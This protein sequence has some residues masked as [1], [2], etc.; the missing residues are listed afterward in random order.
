A[1]AALQYLPVPLIVL[2]SQ[3]TVILA[4]EAMGRLLNIKLLQFP[5]EMERGGEGVMSVTDILHGYSIGQLGIDLLQRGSPILISWEDFLDGVV[6]NSSK[7]P[8]EAEGADTSDHGDSTSRS[9]TPKPGQFKESPTPQNLSRS[10]LNSTTI[11][12]TTIDVLISCDRCPASK[13][14]SSKP[15]KSSLGAPLQATMIISVWTLEEQQYITLTFTSAAPQPTTR[16][17]ERSSTRTVARTN[18]MLRQSPG[19]LSSS[20][21][22]GKGGRRS[23]LS[24]NPSSHGSSPSVRPPVFP[25]S[26][27]PTRSSQSTAHSMFAKASQM[28]DAIL[29][30]TNMPA[31]AMWKDES[32]GIPNRGLLKLHP[33]PEATYEM[34]DLDQSE[35]LSQ[36]KMYTEDFTRRLSVDEFPVV[37]L[38]RNQKPFVSRRIGMRHPETGAKIIFTVHGEM[39]TDDS[40]QFLGGLCTFRDDTDLSNQLAEQVLENAHQLGN[41]ANMIPPIVWTSTSAGLPDWFSQRWYDYTGLT[42]EESLGERWTTSFHPDDMP[43]T[44]KRWAHS[45]ATGD[46]YIVEYRCRRFD[47]MWRWMLGRALPLRDNQGRILKWFGTCTD[48]HELVETRQAAKSLREQ[49]LKVIEHAHVTLWAVD[50]NRNLTL[51]EGNLMWKNT[52]EEGGSADIGPSSIGRNIYEVFGQRQG[53]DDID[54]LKKPIEDILQDRATEEIVE[55][56]IDGSGKW[57]RSRILPLYHQGRN[58]GIDSK[59][60]IDGVIGLSMDVTELRDRE[61]ELRKQERENARLLANAVAAK[62]ASR[63]KSQFLA[64][65]SHEIRTPIAG[66]IGM[67]EILMDTKLDQEQRDCADNIQR[68]ANGLLTVINDILDFSKVESGRLDIEEV[69]FSLSVA[70]RDVNKMLSFAAWKKGLDYECSIASEIERD[71]TVMGDPGRVRQVLTNLLTNSIKFTTS[72]YVHLTVSVIGETDNAVSVQFV[73]EDTGIGIEE[74][75]RKRLFKPFSQADSSTARRFGGTGLGLTIS[76]NLVELMHGKIQLESRLGSG[77]KATFWIP[78]SKVSYSNDGS[79]LVDVTQIPDRLQSDASLSFGSDEMNRNP[80]TPKLSSQQELGHKR[81]HSGSLSRISSIVQGADD[82]VDIPEEERSKIHVLIVEDNQIN[83]QIA[84]K[85]IKKLGFSVNAVWNG[86]EALDYLLRAPTPENPR[87]DIILMDVQMPILDGYRATHTIRTQEPFK[88]SSSIRKIPIVA[89]TASAIQGD[90]EKCKRAGMDDYLAKPVKPKLLEKML[91]K[92]A[93]E[94][95]RKQAADAAKD[96]TDVSSQ[97]FRQLQT[98]TDSSETPLDEPEVPRKGQNMDRLTRHL[99]D[100]LSHIDWANRTAL[101]RSEGSEHDRETRRAAAEEKALS[102]RD[103]KLL[104][105]TENPRQQQHL[106]SEEEKGEA[107]GLGVRQA[108]TKENM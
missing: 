29:N 69:Q 34:A 99:S 80:H 37:D 6:K 86:R 3:K 42:P 26:G 38:V 50:R 95:K 79:P 89:M 68:S 40:G 73:V 13:S 76:K 65:M 81:D 100:K 24:S 9:S 21:S 63:M 94:A 67:S 11:H 58:D 52:P 35:F 8:S 92:W 61:D 64:N 30:S 55:I 102:L 27:P 47:G 14:S 5:N 10:N 51:L 20:S 62:E 84:L 15:A 31:Y 101:N 106:L 97:D 75:V 43:E 28:K 44:S 22:Q 90:R 46:E 93:L 2:S 96:K 71:L 25:P 98:L 56:H 103:D 108:L 18:T 60:F 54:F 87:P 53:G 72:G 23:A 4:N 59:K 85:T 66:V 16:P 41:I 32:F 91:V 7:T 77:T 48:I 12:E 19:S 36:F 33:N 49:L 82:I 105:M 17:I 104:S 88:N 107:R 57:F 83:Q 1:F 45:L 39:I 70:I 78:F 74:E